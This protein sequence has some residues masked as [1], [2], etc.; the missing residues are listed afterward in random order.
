MGTD[1]HPPRYEHQ[2]YV[3]LFGFL[4]ERLS[5]AHQ[6]SIA[7][8]LFGLERSGWR[9]VG[10]LDDLEEAI[11]YSPNA[12]RIVSMPF[13]EHGLSESERNSLGGPVGDAASWV[14]ANEERLVWVHPG[15]RRVLDLDSTTTAWRVC[16]E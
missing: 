15:L 7:T 2:L 6:D 3:D 16:V 12:K 11:F 1:S 10:L 14:D 4:A 9:L 8:E 5:G 13:D